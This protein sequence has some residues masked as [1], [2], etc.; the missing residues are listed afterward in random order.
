MN[1]SRAIKDKN[2]LNVS[3]PQSIYSKVGDKLFNHV[4]VL[5]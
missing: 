5:N 3:D 4:Q 2:L 1:I